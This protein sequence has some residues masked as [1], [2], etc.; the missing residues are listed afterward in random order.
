MMHHPAFYRIPLNADE[1]KHLTVSDEQPTVQSM[2]M[3]S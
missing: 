3:G 1:E 2:F